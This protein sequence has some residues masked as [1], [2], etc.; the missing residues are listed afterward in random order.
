[1]RILLCLLFILSGIGKTAPYKAARITDYKHFEHKCDPVHGMGINDFDTVT[2]SKYYSY[3]YSGIWMEA[4][5]FPD[6]K[7]AQVAFRNA[8]EYY[9]SNPGGADSRKS[10]YRY[11]WDEA[12]AYYIVKGTKIFELHKECRHPEVYYTKYK[13]QLVSELYGKTKPDSCVIEFF[14]GGSKKL[15]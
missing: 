9:I 7:S 4:R 10:I 6:N 3:K 11:L 13:Q 12:G 1:M 15:Q 8:Y 2:V 5:V 14:C